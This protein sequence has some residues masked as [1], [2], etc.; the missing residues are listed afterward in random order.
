MRE[1]FLEWAKLGSEPYDTSYTMND[2]YLLCDTQHAWYGF[3]AAYQLQQSK[4]DKAVEALEWFGNLENYIAELKDN[5]RPQFDFKHTPV[6]NLG[7][8][9]AQQALAEI[10]EIKI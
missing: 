7:Y 5:G 2:I 9:K 3:Q 10:K 4:L 8:E 1:A 6:H